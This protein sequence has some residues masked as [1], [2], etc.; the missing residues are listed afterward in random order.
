[1]AITQDL[2]EFEGKLYAAWK[3]Q[4]GDDRIFYS[5]Y[6][7]SYW[8][9]QN[10]AGGSTSTGP[11]LGTH[12]GRMYLAWKGQHSDQRLF[13]LNVHGGLWSYQSEIP[14]GFGSTGGPALAD[15]NGRLYAAWKGVNED[16]A[17]WF[18]STQDGKN[19]SGQQ[20]IPGVATS[21]GPSLCNYAGHLYAAWK[22][23]N[24]DQAIWFASFDGTSWSPQ[25]SIPGVGSSVGPS[26]AA[27][28]EKLYAIW[29]GVIGDEGLYY[30]HFDGSSWAPQQRIPGVASSVGAA[31]A[32]YGDRLYAMWKGAGADQQLYFSSF[33]GVT[34]APQQIVPGST[35]Q[36]VPVNIGVGLQYQ[37]T[38]LWCWLAIAAS[39]AH[40][41]DGA[42]AVTQCGLMT[43]IGQNINGWP[44]TTMCCP[45]SAVLNANPGLSGVLGNPYSNTAENSLD[46]VGIPQVC[47]KSGGVGDALKVSGNNAGWHPQATLTQI[48]AEL[49]ARRPV[50]VDITWPNGKG[51]V[52]AIAGVLNDHVLI[53]DPANGESVIAF[54]DF[55]AQYS[56][57][58]KLGGYTF[59]KAR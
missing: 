43:T 36:D 54:E 46:S 31:L 24:N 7:G 57:G 41:Y 49:A 8:V 11:S 29:K 44:T 9:E 42:S 26:I 1:M 33:D 51:H 38:S 4:V 14:G 2:H 28:Q 20:T 48:A 16:Q 12:D 55:P 40:F 15:Y 10:L 30:S 53:L 37:E 39:V 27:Y 6:N 3:G 19:W 52:V 47:I 25:A 17:I 32:G 59:T 35:G 21:V 56:G 58:A 18:A 23:M 22:G 34:W 13:N 45:T 50:C 5:F